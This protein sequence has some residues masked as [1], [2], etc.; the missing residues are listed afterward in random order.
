MGYNL[1]IV[2]RWGG[3]DIWWGDKNLVGEESTEGEF[4]GGGMSKFSADGWPFIWVTPENYTILA[5]PVTFKECWVPP[6][7]CAGAHY[8]L[9]LSIY[10]CW[11]SN[12]S[13]IFWITHFGKTFKLFPSSK[14]Y[15]N[16]ELPLPFLQKF[17]DINLSLSYFSFLKYYF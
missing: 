11:F 5:P 9:S 13:A 14:T 12:K 3:V 17:Q 1:K 10:C 16:E 2:V 4:L 15:F 7:S 8:G 6:E